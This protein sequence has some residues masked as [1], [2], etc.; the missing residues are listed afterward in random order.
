MSG[1][2]TGRIVKELLASYLAGRFLIL[3]L[4]QSFFGREDHTLADRLLLELPGIL[5]WSIGGWR[6]LSA[7]GRFL[8]PSAGQDTIDQMNDLA[9]AISAFIREWCVVK[10]GITAPMKDAFLAWQLW[11]EEQGQERPGTSQVFGR[12]LRSAVP[13]IGESQ[14]YINRERVRVYTGIGLKAHGAEAV[15]AAKA[16]QAAQETSSRRWAS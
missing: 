4:E 12:D 5:R 15:A 8:Q 1:S 16:K 3:K 11:C 9:S 6:R 10:A 7:R 13:G 14:P 2:K